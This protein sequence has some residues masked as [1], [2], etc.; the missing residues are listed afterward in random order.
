MRIDVEKKNN[1]AIL[2][3]E[4]KIIGD[5]VPRFKQATE[6]QI[7]SGVRW[8][9]MNLAEVPMMDSSGLGVLITA[10]VRL[11]E[12]RGKLVLLYVPEN[13]LNILTITKL[14]T[15]FD[16]SDD[17]QLALRSVEMDS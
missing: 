10:F 7:D 11:R 1:G 9:I 6:E 5:S 4:G 17:I 16:I 12:K 2:Y 15:L 3:L 14:N 13:L 8:L